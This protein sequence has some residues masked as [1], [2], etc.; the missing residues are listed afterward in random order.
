MLSGTASLSTGDRRGQACRASRSGHRRGR[1]RAVSQ[2][3]QRPREPSRPD[4]P[5]RPPAGPRSCAVPARRRAGGLTVSTEW[6]LLPRTQQ[7]AHVAPAGSPRKRSRSPPSW[8]PAGCTTRPNCSDRKY[9]TPSKTAS[10]PSSMAAAT[11]G[12][13]ARP[14]RHRER[15]PLVWLLGL[16]AGDDAP[17]G[18]DGTGSKSVERTVAGN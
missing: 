3:R 18:P 17:H 10:R 2:A 4:A 8:C 5:D 11:A 13:R 16:G 9:R 15:G 14:G 6:R 12:A 7:V 1:R